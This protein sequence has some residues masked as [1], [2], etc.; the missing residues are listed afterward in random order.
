MRL[1]SPKDPLQW[2]FV[3][4]GRQHGKTVQNS[5][6][7][8]TYALGKNPD[9]R[10]GIVSYG[11]QHARKIGGRC[12]EKFERFGPRIWEA[13]VSRRSRS[14][15]YWETTAGGAVISCG[16]EGP[17]NGES[18]DLLILDDLYKD[19]KQAES[20]KYRDY[21]FDWVNE[22]ALPAVKETGG[23]LA[24]NTRWHREDVIGKML[25]MHGDQVVQVGS[26]ILSEYIAF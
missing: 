5:I 25:K 23:I 18:L 26:P 1:I 20:E 24:C 4:L 10:I 11:G 3:I 15:S 22:I 2:L 17:L 12:R 6:N 7:F 16:I 19:R 21:V 14:K 13:D 9:W 8:P